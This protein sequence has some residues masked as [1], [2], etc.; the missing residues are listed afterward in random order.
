MD[1]DTSAVPDPQDPNTFESSKLDWS[2]LERPEHAELLELT[3][4]LIEIRHTYPDFTDPRFD[5]GHAT[6]DDEDGWVLIERGKV[7]MAVNFHD[8]PTEVEVGRDVV[9]VFTIGDTEVDGGT[10]RL[11][12]H[13]ALVADAT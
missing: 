13:S 8:H 1:W 6:S 4:R 2:E 10:V 7:I 3:T 5:Q 11:G 12:P 9:P